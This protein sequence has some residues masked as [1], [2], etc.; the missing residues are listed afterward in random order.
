VSAVDATREIHYIQSVFHLAQALRPP[1]EFTCK[2]AKTNRRPNK[3]P[4]PLLIPLA[5]D[6][7]RN[8]TLERNSSSSEDKAKLTTSSHVLSSLFNEFPKTF[9]NR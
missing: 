3:T 7:K 9:P 5:P 6:R 8:I 4:M 1:V 2:S